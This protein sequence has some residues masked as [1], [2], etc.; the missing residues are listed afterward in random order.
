MG[1]PLLRPSGG[2]PWQPITGGSHSDL[3]APL[4]AHVRQLGYSGEMRDLPENGPGG[5]CDPKRNQIV[6]AKDRP[7]GSSARW[8]TSLRTRTASATNPAAS[9]A[10]CS[11]TA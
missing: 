1:R 7:T 8:C 2:A 4:I 11:W 9:A 3:I 10:R 6:I 5:W